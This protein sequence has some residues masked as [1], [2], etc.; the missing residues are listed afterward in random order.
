MKRDKESLVEL[1]DITR[2][3]VRFTGTHEGLE[4]DK[5]IESS[6]RLKKTSQTCRRTQ[7]SRYMK[8]EG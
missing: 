7:I 1:W 2:S 3:T 4:T 8:I 5:T 6:K